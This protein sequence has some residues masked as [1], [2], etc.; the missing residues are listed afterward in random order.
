MTSKNT[1]GKSPVV[2]TR[3]PGGLFVLLGTDQYNEHG[4]LQYPG[5]LGIKFGRDKTDWVRMSYSDA[6]LLYRFIEEN[7]DFINSQVQA[8]RDRLT[9]DE[10]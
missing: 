4:D 10:I 5:K 8:E 9:V 1:L 7:R 3:L 2:S 6:V